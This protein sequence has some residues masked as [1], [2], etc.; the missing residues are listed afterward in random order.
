MEYQISVAQQPAQNALVIEHSLGREAVPQFLNTAFL[1]VAE[2][3]AEHGIQPSGPPF[4]RYRVDGD[5][6]HV[7]AGIPVPVG[8][9]GSGRVQPA[10]LPGGD[11]AS[12]VHVGSYEDL[13]A[14]FHAVM[15]WL[16]GAGYAITG[17]P[18]ES[19]LDGPDVPQPRTQVNFP[20]TRST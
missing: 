1:E 3:L 19:Y 17:D 7:T 8:V 4:A 2:I 12:T 5:T 20:V 9:T 15:E 13:P 14:A 10:E 6:F 16:P 18:W 11:V